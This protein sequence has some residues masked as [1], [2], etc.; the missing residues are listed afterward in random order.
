MKTC[1][2][3]SDYFKVHQGF[4]VPSLRPKYAMSPKPRH[5]VWGSNKDLPT[6]PF[7]G[8]P[9]PCG[10]LPT[11]PTSFGRRPE[12]FR[13]DRNTHKGQLW[14]W[15]NTVRIL[16]LHN[17][18]RVRVLVRILFVPLWTKWDLWRFGHLFQRLAVGTNG[19]KNCL[20]LEK[21]M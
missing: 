10:N 16:S 14:C 7:E 18:E 8:S 21:K 13:T 4:F 11:C 6:S 20:I 15:T 1:C 19:R 12:I 3:K 9:S 17:V 2:K 5:E